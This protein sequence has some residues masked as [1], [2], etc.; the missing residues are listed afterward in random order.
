MFASF[1]KTQP[2]K[3]NSKEYDDKKG[4][5]WYDYGARMYD[6][7]TGRFTMVDPMV[8][9]AYSGS[10]YAYCLNN[11]FKLV[12]PTG[13]FASTHTD[14][15]GNVVNA[16]NDGDLGVY[17][18]NTDRK[19]T[20]AELAELHSRQ[21][22]TAGGDRMGRT[23]Y[24]DEFVPFLNQGITINY[25]TTFDSEFA[26][27]ATFTS[28]MDIITLAKKSRG[29]GKLDTKRKLGNY[30]A[31]FR[32]SYMTT[33]SLENYLAGYN[34]GNANIS[35]EAF[36]KLAGALHIEKNFGNR[37]LTKMQMLSIILLGNYKSLRP[38]LFKAPQWGEEYYQYRMSKKGW[39]DAFR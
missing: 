36:Q 24:W 18:H 14:S 27:Y 8:E 31:T 33:R 7:T 9:N 37:T 10:S 21:Y 29:N 35:F 22:T 20:L 15:L 2:Y 4:L 28:T 6:A 39:Q 38:D 23:L 17:R 26:N 3:Y 5:N 32:G 13:C 34:A 30:G 19:G 1:G 25:G 16:F 12:D 11:P